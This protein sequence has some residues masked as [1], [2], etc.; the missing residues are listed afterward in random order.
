M[1]LQEQTLAIAFNKGIQTKS[2]PKQLQIGELQVLQNAVFTTI[3]QISKRYGYNNLTLNIL[4]GSTLSVGNS[5]A[6]LNTT[7]LTLNNNKYLYSYIPGQTE[8]VNRG[9]QVASSISVLPVGNN[10]DQYSLPQVI[11]GPNNTNIYTWNTRI[12]SSSLPLGGYSIVDT[13]SN[14]VVF[15]AAIGVI[16]SNTLPVVFGNTL[17][18]LM[19]VIGGG[20]D[21]LLLGSTSLTSP[22]A[23]NSFTTFATLLATTKAQVQ[24]VQNTTNA[25]VLYQDASSNLTLVKTDNTMTASSNVTVFNGT[26]NS[27]E[28][29]YDSTNNYLWVIYT[30]STPQQRLVIYDTNLN[31]IQS[32]ITIATLNAVRMSAIVKNGTS[33]YAYAETVGST[34]PPFDNIVQN[35]TYVIGSGT[36]SSIAI[37]QA[38]LATKPW[39][40]SGNNLYI[41]IVHRSSL[42]ST[43][44]VIKDNVL[45]GT[46]TVT[47]APWTVITKYAEGTASPTN[48][49]TPSGVNFYSNTSKIIGN[50]TDSFTI[51]FNLNT[52]AT[53]ALGV[54]TA[55]FNTYAAFITLNTKMRSQS[56][57]NNLNYTGGLCTLTDGIG[58]FEAG[59]NLFPEY[60]SVVQGGAGALPGGQQYSYVAVYKFVDAQGNVHRSAPGPQPA[61]TY[62]PADSAHSAT[63]SVPILDM[64]EHYKKSLVQIELYRNAPTISATVFYLIQVKGNNGV[65]GY[66]SFTDNAADSSITANRQLYTT[67][68][69]VENI[70]PPTSDIFTVFKNRI[71]AVDS[72]SPYDW[73]YSKQVLHGSPVEYNDS[74]VQSIDQRGGVIKALAVLDDKLILFKDN[75]IFYVIGDGPA[76]AGT[77]NDFTYPQVITTDVGCINPDSVVQTPTGIMFMSRKGIYLLDRGLATSYIGAPVEAYNGYTITSAL[78]IP[79]TTQ[80]RFTTN[81]NIILVYDYFVQ[82]W[83]IFTGFS[84]I[85]AAIYNNTYTLVSS[86]GQVSTETVGAY[87]D[88]GNPIAIYLKTAWFSFAGVQGFERIKKLLILGESQTPTSLQVQFAYD[89]SNTI[90]QT[91][92]IPILNAATPIQYRVFPSKQKCETMQII[93]TETPQ[94]PYGQGLSL[95]NFEFELGIKKGPYKLPSSQSYG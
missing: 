30:D 22:S 41:G 64:T 61:A 85:G 4:G 50:G 93:V 69:E 65:G 84:P 74:F 71:I 35:F 36:S 58:V 67:G 91:T 42:Q 78:V 54:T 70:A 27:T 82:Q 89:Y 87:T 19:Q 45:S 79:N 56:L 43:Y 3:G 63:I 38:C 23:I 6:V 51:P 31:V 26:V 40:D 88:A 77:N 59:F 33:L 11:A 53:K 57:A 32:A 46:S 47:G 81:N 28:L 72:Q 2:D 8:W 44:F 48:I 37:N 7:T 49:D 60:V 10:S 15:A 66:V 39:L 95:S 86:T 21:S 55:G 83:S 17:Y 18:T 24:V 68:G 20:S 90:N 34:N 73:W 94:T 1:P 29:V 5:I 92:T 12:V 75:I 13:T 62:T 16:S 76:P 14:S 9:D 80:V 25:F 52:D